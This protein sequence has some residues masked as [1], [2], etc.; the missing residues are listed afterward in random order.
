MSIEQA[1]NLAPAQVNAL[2]A[3]MLAVAHVDGIHAHE[4]ALIRKFYEES[5]GA[6]APPFSTVEGIH[7]QAAELLKAAGGGADFAE[8][9][10]L[11]CL[12]AGYADGHLS[13]GERAVV[14]QLAHGAGVSAEKVEEL[15]QQVKDT[16]I[17]SLAHLPDAQS[18]ADLAKTL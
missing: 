1:D 17:G 13:E 18:V 16:L 15:L 5:A 6:D 10:V 7:G 14:D 11:M 12:M 4:L 9:L 3:S 8:Q 2:V